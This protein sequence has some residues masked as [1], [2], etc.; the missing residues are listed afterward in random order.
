MPIYVLHTT[1]DDRPAR[2]IFVQAITLL[3]AQTFGTPRAAVRVEV[4]N[5]PR[6]GSEMWSEHYGGTGFQASA[7]LSKFTDYLEVKLDFRGTRDEWEDYCR[8]IVSI[9]PQ[10]R[11]IYLQ[12]L[13]F[14][15]ERPDPSLLGGLVTPPRKGEGRM[16]GIAALRGQ[17]AGGPVSRR[18]SVDEESLPPYQE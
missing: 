7:G 5:A 10:I 1:E 9:R 17:L 15:F 8:E 12:R 6:Q 14:E 16:T 4:V 3:H 11:S 2:V 13:E 18:R